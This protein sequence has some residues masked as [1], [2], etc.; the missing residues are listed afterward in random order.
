MSTPLHAPT[1]P[2]TNVRDAIVGLSRPLAE[3]R[4]P[5]VWELVIVGALVGLAAYLRL[6]ALGTPSLWVD[7]T[8]S[9][10][11][12]HYPWSA[13]W[14]DVSDS[15]PPLYYS[16]VKIALLFGDSEFVIRM[17]GVIAGTLT[18]AVVYGIGRLTFGPAA[19]VAAAVALAVSNVHIDYSQDARMY[20]VLVFGLSLAT[21]GAVGLGHARSYAVPP[22]SKRRWGTLFWASLATYAVGTLIA[23]YSQNIAVFVVALLQAYALWLWIRYYERAK[24]FLIA[25]LAVGALVLVLWVP[26][27]MIVAAYL[28]DGNPIAWLVNPGPTQAFDQWRSLIGYRYFDTIRPVADVLVLAILA[29]GVFKA[30]AFAG[31]APLLVMIVVVGPLLVWLAGFFAPMYMV[32]TTMWVLI[33]SS[34][35]IGAA[36][37]ASHKL[38]AVG[39]LVAVTILGLI[40]TSVYFERAER[41]DWRGQS[42]YLAAT[43]GDGDAV[44]VCAYLAQV[45]L[46]FYEPTVG[47]RLDI[48]VWQPPEQVSRQQRR[49]PVAVSNNLYDPALL[50]SSRHQRIW[51]VDSHCTEGFIV[52]NRDL[53]GAGWAATKQKDARGVILHAYE[54]L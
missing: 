40:S 25:W 14:S 48:Y 8:S 29:Y 54:R 28:S 37:A 43:A 51:I 35:A 27:L 50:D 52:L 41:E 22:G 46:L 7:E 17:P 31:F 13:L 45:P 39:A 24:V 38:V 9:V 3:Y 16:L 20:G 21:L 15:H 1:R 34:L 42:A 12:A 18:V 26:W 53:V 5:L 11:F 4:L 36:V 2:R 47:E 33:G 23:L 44:I 10:H 6:H 49:T 32:R 19:G 30:R